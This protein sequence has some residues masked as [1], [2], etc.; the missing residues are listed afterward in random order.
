MNA[1]ALV[2]LVLCF[3]LAQSAET[4]GNGQPIDPAK[5]GGVADQPKPPSEAKTPVAPAKK[6]S[7]ELLRAKKRPAIDPTKTGAPAKQPEAPT[8]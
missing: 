4:L 1:R 3:V 2:C 8:Q 7:K 5:A 6:R